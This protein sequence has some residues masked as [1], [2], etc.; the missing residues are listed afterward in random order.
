MRLSPDGTPPSLIR[1]CTMLAWTDCRDRRRHIGCTVPRYL[2]N[3]AYLCIIHAYAECWETQI[4]NVVH[5]LVL[6]SYI[7]S[8]LIL[9]INAIC[10]TPYNK[11]DPLASHHHNVRRNRSEVDPPVLVRAAPPQ[12]TKRQGGC[13]TA[14]KIRELQG[15]EMHI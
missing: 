8:Q 5:R 15:E 2:S 3:V 9:V 13:T 4:Y 12:L 1:I 6:S 7:I 11:T 14:D 10:R